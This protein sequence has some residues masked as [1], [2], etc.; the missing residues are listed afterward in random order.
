MYPM[1]FK[2]EVFISF[3]QYKALVENLFSSKIQQLQ[4]DNGGEYI[5]NDFKSFLTKHGIYHRLTCPYTSQQNRIVERKHRH[6]Q[7]TGLTLL[8]KAQLPNKYWTDAFLTAVFLINW[9][10]TKVLKNI[11]PYF[12]LHKTMPSYTSQRTFGCAC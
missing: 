12:L 7:E 6:I 5:S 4:S 3:Q 10:P 8:A 9:L 11:S 2:S 1:C